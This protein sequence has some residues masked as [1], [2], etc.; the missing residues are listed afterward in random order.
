MTTG[1]SRIDSSTRL[2]VEDQ[3]HEFYRLV[4]TG[5]ASR[6]A[7]MFLPT[8]SLTLGPGSPQPG[9]IQGPAIRDAMFAREK[10]TSAF[11]RHAVSNVRY[12]SEKENVINTAYLLVLYRSD[13]SSRSSVPAFVADVEELWKATDDGWKIATRVVMPTFFRA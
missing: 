1:I 11:T 7:A 3:I 8:A 4:D 10:V 9:T 6:T 5:H 13:D 2:A 12:S